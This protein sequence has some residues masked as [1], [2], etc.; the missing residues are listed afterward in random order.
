MG[1]SAQLE[2]EQRELRAGDVGVVVG[3]ACVVVVVACVVDVVVEIAFWPTAS[4]PAKVAGSVI[5]FV[6]VAYFGALE[7]YPAV[8]RAPASGASD[9]V[10]ALYAAFAVISWRTC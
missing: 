7:M 5:P 1:G 3:V 8:T 9:P 6:N 2:T 4:Q 10:L